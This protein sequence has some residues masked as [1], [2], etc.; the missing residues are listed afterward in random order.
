MVIR[1][2]EEVLYFS[3][4]TLVMLA[5]SGTYYVVFR[6]LRLKALP[7]SISLL[8]CQK[9]Y[10]TGRGKRHRLR[11]SSPT[12]VSLISIPAHAETTWQVLL[13]Y[14]PHCVSWK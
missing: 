4:S 1:H 11:Q 14:C 12:C 5:R 13:E 7:V 10:K 2:D 9:V 8:L 6:S 3:S